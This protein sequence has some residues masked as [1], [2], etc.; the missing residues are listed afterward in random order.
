MSRDLLVV[1]NSTGS[2][3]AD[4]T[5]KEGSGRDHGSVIP[6]AQ[7]FKIESR[8]IIDNSL[9]DGISRSHCLHIL[10]VKQKGESIYR[11]HPPCFSRIYSQSIESLQH[12]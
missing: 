5:I 2:G 4:C 1:L 7:R 10:T 12:R 3:V 11:I 8:S 6:I 9:L